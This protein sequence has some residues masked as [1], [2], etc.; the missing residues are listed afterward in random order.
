MQKE[1]FTL[2][3]RNIWRNKRRSYITMSSIAFAVLLSCLM[4]SVQYGSLDH[5]VD[6]VVKFYAGHIQI[7][8]DRYWDEK[9]IDHSLEVYPGMVDSLESLPSIETVVPRIESFALSAYETRTKAAMLL[10]IDPQREK[11]IIDVESRI[12]NNDCKMTKGE[13]SWR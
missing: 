6:N 4:M 3:W 7:H 11:D 1:F 8:D 12:P 5:M 2:A 13:V 10:G 9:I